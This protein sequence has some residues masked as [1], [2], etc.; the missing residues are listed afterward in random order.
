MGD[1]IKRSV[2]LHD[3]FAEEV[4]VCWKV[5]Q[6]EAV[7]F[8]FNQEVIARVAMKIIAGYAIAER[9]VL[10]FGGFGSEMAAKRIMPAAGVSGDGAKHAAHVGVQDE[11]LGEMSCML[12]LESV[13]HVV[14]LR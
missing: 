4:H 12:R 11:A 6:R 5:A 14:A 8:Q 13:G 1:V 3:H 9:A 7:L 10:C 2:I